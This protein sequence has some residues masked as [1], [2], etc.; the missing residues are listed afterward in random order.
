MDPTMAFLA[1]LLGM[2]NAGRSAQPEA[3]PHGRAEVPLSAYD[4]SYISGG[5]GENVIDYAAQASER[6]KTQ[7]VCSHFFCI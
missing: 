7:R 1:Q 2:M 5:H 6:H 4:E 3:D